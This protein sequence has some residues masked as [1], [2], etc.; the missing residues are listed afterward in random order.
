MGILLGR[1]DGNWDVEMDGECVFIS[2][3]DVL[4]PKDTFE[5]RNDGRCVGR[6][7]GIAFG[8]KDGNEDTEIDGEG[9]GTIDGGIV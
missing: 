1:D 9:E 6:F 7:D 3:G 4:G 5:G 2:D 8:I